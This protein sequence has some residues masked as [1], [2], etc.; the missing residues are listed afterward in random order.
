MR[1]RNDE[2]LPKKHNINSNDRGKS[3]CT[4]R[5]YLSQLIFQLDVKN[6]G[7]YLRQLNK[8]KPCSHC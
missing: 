5:I 4:V 7:Q 2:G 8:M 3:F 1:A 6:E